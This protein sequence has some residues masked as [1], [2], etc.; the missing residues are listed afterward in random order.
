MPNDISIFGFPLKVSTARYL[1]IGGIIL[2][3]LVISVLGWQIYKL[4]DQGSESSR[5]EV[6]YGSKLITVHENIIPRNRTIEVASM[7]E[8]AKIAER[9][10]SMIMHALHGSLHHYFIQSPRVP[11][12]TYHYQ[13]YEDQELEVLPTN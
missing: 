9:D 13:L 7:Q 8:L 6:L 10:Q 4:F 12:L 5:I 2:T 11:D 1:S 3:V